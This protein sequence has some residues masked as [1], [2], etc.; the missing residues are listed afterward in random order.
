MPKLETHADLE[1]IEEAADAI[2]QELPEYLQRTNAWFTELVLACRPGLSIAGLSERSGPDD[3]EIDRR[4]NAQIELGEKILQSMEPYF[5]RVV[6]QMLV[7][8]AKEVAAAA[9][10]TA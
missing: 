8:A 9:A 2:V 10:V 7:D 6:K 1:A 4:L 5:S 3:A